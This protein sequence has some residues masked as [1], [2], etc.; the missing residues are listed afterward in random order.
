MNRSQTTFLRL[1]AHNDKAA[2][3]AASVDA[4]RDGADHPDVGAGRL[5]SL[6]CADFRVGAR[7]IVPQRPRIRGLAGDAVGSVGATTWGRPYVLFYS[8]FLRCATL[9]FCAGLL[10]ARRREGAGLTTGG[11]PSPCCRKESQ[12]PGPMIR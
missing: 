10:A 6:G 9:A 5:I 8:P 1:L 12:P 4:L 7:Y 2:A 11:K 3:L